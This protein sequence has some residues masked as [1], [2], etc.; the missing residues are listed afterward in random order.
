M[1]ASW[2][3]DLRAADKAPRTIEIYSQAVTFYGRWLEAQGDR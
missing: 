3:R 1:L 2:Q